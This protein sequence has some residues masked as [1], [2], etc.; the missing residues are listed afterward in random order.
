M[1]QEHDTLQPFSE[2]VAAIAVQEHAPDAPEDTTP[3]D[4]ASMVGNIAMQVD[5]LPVS[6]DRRRR[7]FVNAVERVEPE[8]DD[9]LD[10]RTMRHDIVK[11]VAEARFRK[12]HHMARRRIL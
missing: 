8:I 2:A 5:A 6:K 7:V 11:A 9:L 1:T 3:A 10:V 4:V 12:A